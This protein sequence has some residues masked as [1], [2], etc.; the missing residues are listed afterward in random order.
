[1]L[2]LFVFLVCLENCVL[3]VA[4]ATTVCNLEDFG[5]KGDA[6][7]DNTLILRH[8]LNHC[9][10][11]FVPQG[12]WLTGPINITK[13]S[14]QVNG[15]LVAK[16]DTTTWPVMPHLPSYP[17][18]RDIC[19][20]CRYQ[21]FVLFAN[22]TNVSLTGDGTIDGSGPFWWGLRNQ[23][24]LLYGRPRLVETMW[25][26]GITIKGVTL[27]DSGFWVTHIWASD[28]VE[29]AF[30]N[31]SSRGGGNTDGFD[32]DSSTNVHIHD[33]TVTNSDDCISVKS[34]MDAPGRAFGRPSRNILIE[35][36]QCF[37]GDGL[38]MG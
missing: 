21:P 18:D 10:V 24:K 38:A 5:G 20:C 2:V 4:G 9:N 1:M 3:K 22:A 8:L 26:V 19:S 13:A 28:Q 37:H 17:C 14:L 29:I 30:V 11:V 12:K 35:N 6:V 36:L 27:K 16:N 34:G 31:V 23:K 15:T 32:P 33:C 25:S 7:F